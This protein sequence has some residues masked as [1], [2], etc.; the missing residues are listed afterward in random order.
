MAAQHERN[1]QLWDFEQLA[2]VLIYD[3]L[4]YLW[5]SVN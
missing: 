5:S 4:E 2:E 3:W 1:V